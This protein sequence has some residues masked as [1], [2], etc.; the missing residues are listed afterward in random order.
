MKC[1]RTST[2]TRPSPKNLSTSLNGISFHS[3]QQSNFKIDFQNLTIVAEEIRSLSI[4]KEVSGDLMVAQSR[5]LSSFFSS[6]RLVSVSTTE[7][8]IGHYMSGGYLT[9]NSNSNTI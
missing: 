9:N 8:I 5:A 4:K 1:R 3:S 7:Q 2:L 6:A